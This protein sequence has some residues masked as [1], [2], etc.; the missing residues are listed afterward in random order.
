MVLENSLIRWLA[1]SEFWRDALL[2]MLIL[3]AVAADEAD[4]LIRELRVA[5]IG[6]ATVIGRAREE[7]L[8]GIRVR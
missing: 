8:A 1:I 7:I 5:G 3:L 6:Q 4:A 2:G